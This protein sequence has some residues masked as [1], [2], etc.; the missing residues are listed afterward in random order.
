MV[1]AAKLSLCHTGHQAV[2]C[3]HDDSGARSSA[4]LRFIQ[5]GDWY[6]AGFVKSG[7]GKTPNSG[8]AESQTVLQIMKTFNGCL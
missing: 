4:R 3:R 8:C 5:T 6:G 7:M 2:S 1:T